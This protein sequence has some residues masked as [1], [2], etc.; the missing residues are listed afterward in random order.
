MTS[1]PSQALVSPP[2]R[3]TPNRSASSR[4]PAWSPCATATASARGKRDGHDGGAR[5][6]GHGRDV[7]EVHPH[8]LVADGLGPV[9]LEPEMAAVHQHV[10]RDQ[11]V[12]AARPTPQDRAVVAD[13]QPGPAA[14]IEAPR[15]G[16]SSR[17]GR[18][19]RVSLRLSMRLR[20]NCLV[21][22]RDVNVS[23]RDSVA[24]PPETP[25][26]PARS[27]VPGACRPGS[28]ASSRLIGP[29]QIEK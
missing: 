20:V 5:N 15:A 24:R 9:L 21:R 10:G 19:R 3:S 2:T 12:G 11:E 22:S 17:S 8:R 7:R 29:G 14:A 26:R 25:A 1:G 18:I 13:A 28:I 16:G 23:C 4:I 6:A 27:P